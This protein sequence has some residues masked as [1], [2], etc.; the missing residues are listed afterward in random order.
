M[1]GRGQG[2]WFAPVTT[3]KRAVVVV[4]NVSATQLHLLLCCS[5]TSGR[6]VATV[7]NM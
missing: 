7:A 3:A 6:A 5:H 1:D 2:G 4:V